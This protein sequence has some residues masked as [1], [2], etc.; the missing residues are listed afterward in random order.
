MAELSDPLKAVFISVYDMV[1]NQLAGSVGG[2]DLSV[3]SLRYK[4][5]DE[6]DDTCIIKFQMSDPKSLDILKI[7]RGTKLQI[8][9][10]Y[11]NNP[12]SPTTTVVV[13]D[14]TSKYGSNVIY[15]ELECTDY[16]TYLKVA[17]SPDVAEGSVIDFIKAQVYGRYNIVIKDR[18]N[19]IYAQTKRKEGEEY[20][21]LLQITVPENWPHFAGNVIF[22]PLDDHPSKVTETLLVK[23]DPGIGKWYVDEAHP[24]REYLEKENRIP[25][26]NRS[27]YIVIQDLMKICPNGP[28]FVTGR[29][30]TLFIHNRDLGRIIYKEY[31]Y[32]DEPGHLIDFTPKTK[33]E[34]FDKQMISY[35]GMD[36]KHRKNF[37]I[38]DYRIALK[39]QRNPKEIL[40]DR[41]I[42]LEEKAKELKEYTQLRL[43]GY[44]NFGHREIEGAFFNPGTPKQLFLPGKFDKPFVLKE[45]KPLFAVPDHTNVENPDPMI[46]K[47]EGGFDPAIHDKILRAMWY[48]FPLLTFSEAVNQT[49][50]RQRELAMDKEEAKIILE[51]DPWVKSELTIRVTNVHSQHEGHYYIKKCE[52]I[53][54]NQGYKT[55]LDCLKVVP[56]AR[57]KTLSNIT[58]DEYFVE[59]DSL[60]EVQSDQL[61]REQALFG[62]DVVITYHISRDMGYFKPY[63]MGDD[64]F[65]TKYKKKEVRFGDILSNENYTDDQFVKDAISALS[66]TD[67]SVTFD[68]ED[69]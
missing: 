10:G 1:G 58:K 38:D 26:S 46:R 20:D 3:V 31:R 55:Q 63:G 62:S 52:H 25:T 5:D 39:T 12:V 17:R 57:I 22:D 43:G 45:P 65:H 36:P 23:E 67:I 33:F 59:D 40:E 42:T 29:G 4:Y 7:I 56:E 61:K 41:K 68:P 11:L 35:A 19:R 34:N 53:L 30:S 6:D 47:D 64:Q 48:T 66:Q 14:M 8:I 69:K 13:R 18:G 9:W 15:T 16:L 49:N 60:R 28:W 24:L 54:T 32:K 37:F 2:G 51:G 50:N 44:A 27:T 21:E